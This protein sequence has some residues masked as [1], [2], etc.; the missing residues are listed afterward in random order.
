MIQ[1]FFFGSLDRYFDGLRRSGRLWA[2][3]RVLGIGSVGEVLVLH[4]LEKVRRA[5]EHAPQ[6]GF[7]LVIRLPFVE[8]SDLRLHQKGDELTLRAGAYRR[9]FILPR[10]LQ[11][12][13]V[14]RARFA[15]GTL[16]VHFN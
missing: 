8:K 16:R 2:A 5:V 14:A 3:C 9:N 1:K 11:N 6:G 7:D 13:L 15:D 12:R 4:A 10:T